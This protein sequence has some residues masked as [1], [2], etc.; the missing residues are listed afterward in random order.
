MQKVRPR[1][2]VTRQ[3]ENRQAEPP[4]S[5]VCCP[6]AFRFT[7]PRYKGFPVKCSDRIGIGMG[8]LVDSQVV[9]HGNDK[10][11]R[12]A[13]SRLFVHIRQGIPENCLSTS[14]IEDNEDRVH[15]VVRDRP[16]GH[17]SFPRKLLPGVGDGL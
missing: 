9:P 2:G 4:D 3:E 16:A 13:T 14:H 15:F 7:L 1:S 8:Y 17:L 11:P 12:D 10:W 5:I 6:S